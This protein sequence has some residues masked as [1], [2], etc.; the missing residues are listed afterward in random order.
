MTEILKTVASIKL[1]STFLLKVIFIKHIVNNYK[2]HITVV[3]LMVIHFL[4][5]EVLRGRHGMK[6]GAF[7][8]NGAFL[9][10]PLKSP[11]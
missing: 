8:T 1:S 11:F 6:N 2:T 7:L 4:F 9:A 3:A 5:L 10:N